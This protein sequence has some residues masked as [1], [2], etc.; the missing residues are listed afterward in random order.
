MAQSI[1]YTDDSNGETEIDM[2]HTG[3]SSI[4]SL[5]NRAVPTVF[6]RCP[7]T[8]KKSSLSRE[9]DPLD[10]SDQFTDDVPDSGPVSRQQNFPRRSSSFTETVPTEPTRYNYQNFD[11]SKSNRASDD[12]EEQNE[13]ATLQ[14]ISNFDKHKVETLQKRNSNDGK[15]LDRTNDPLK[16]RGTELP[17]NSSNLETDPFIRDS[18]DSDSG[19]SFRSD[20]DDLDSQLGILPFTKM[21]KKLQEQT[22]QEFDD[23]ID[24]L[25]KIGSST[26]DSSRLHGSFS[27]YIRPN[28]QREDGSEYVNISS[29]ENMVSP[30]AL[31]PVDYV[32]KSIYRTSVL[33]NDSNLMTRTKEA[34]ELSKVLKKLK[35]KVLQDISQM[36]DEMRET[37][38][39]IFCTRIFFSY[40][41]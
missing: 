38:K 13:Q 3:I 16:N 7:A 27:K 30:N 41:K 21:N 39:P 14:D 10:T 33:V 18:F 37:G 26:P 5:A 25:Y 23:S 29:L 19:S 24:P 6:C 2:H 15:D 22:S 32:M 20:S 40:S 31:P 11:S 12:K 28:S 35:K 17:Q 8:K 36:D 9:T 1:H 4:G 34:I